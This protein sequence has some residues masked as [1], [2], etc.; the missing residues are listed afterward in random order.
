MI[1]TS[2]ALISAACMATLVAVPT[3]LVAAC[4]LHF[5]RAGQGPG[6][7]L[8]KAILSLIVWIPV[9]YGML[10]AQGV[11]MFLVTGTPSDREAGAAVLLFSGLVYLPIAYAIARGVWHPG[12][13]AS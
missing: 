10:F 8:V 4:V 6:R 1:E 5:F 13:S 11:G 9:S 2:A 3:L 12:R 7:V